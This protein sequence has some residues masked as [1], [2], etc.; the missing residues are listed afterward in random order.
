MPILQQ[1]QRREEYLKDLKNWRAQI[2]LRTTGPDFQNTVQTI[3]S[4]IDRASRDGDKVV[5][6]LMMSYDKEYDD[7][8][9]PFS[10]PA[11]PGQ[12][13]PTMDSTRVTLVRHRVQSLL[14]KLISEMETLVNQ[15]TPGNA[16]LSS[17]A[18]KPSN[19]TVTPDNPV[20]R[21]LN[22]TARII[23]NDAAANPTLNRTEIGAASDRQ[24]LLQLRDMQERNRTLAESLEKEQEANRSLQSELEQAKQHYKVKNANMETLL[25]NLKRGQQEELAEKEKVIIALRSEIQQKESEIESL[26]RQFPAQ[27]RLPEL[28]TTLQ[29]PAGPFPPSLQSF[30]AGLL[31]VARRANEGSL[32]ELS[33]QESLAQLDQFIY[34]PA[35]AFGALALERPGSVEPADVVRV[36]SLQSRVHLRLAEIGLDTIRP[37]PGD[38][39]DR[40]LH[41]FSEQD[42]ILNNDD[43]DRHGRI[44]GVKRNGYRNT[45][46]GAVLR[47]ADVQR[48]IYRDYGI[49]QDSTAPAEEDAETGGR[50]DA[51]TSGEPKSEDADAYAL[52]K[53]AARSP[54]K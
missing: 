49:L 42:L 35:P 13:R 26:K 28:I 3:R 29:F 45:Q 41:A 9:S 30:V 23:H 38:E 12:P 43:P 18:S 33:S 52:L 32:E 22:E 31:A 10:G 8:I 51:E 27:Q 54:R 46:T 1:Q 7:A 53:K 24:L 15:G 14:D 17:Q 36:V 6:N 40:R 47:R 39:Y 37:Q 44:A 2:T 4:L 5:L 11:E 34:R 19:R 20:F 50:G 25:D 21:D 48:W 16:S